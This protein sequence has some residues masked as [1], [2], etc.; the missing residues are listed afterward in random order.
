MRSLSRLTLS[1]TLTWLATVGLAGGCELFRP[2]T[3]EG[4]PPA[5]ELVHED[6]SSPEATLATMVGAVAAKV[7]GVRSWMNSLA[8]PQRDNG[9]AF[10]ALFDET[11]VLAY[12]TG[13]P[14]SWGRTQEETFYGDFL[15]KWRTGRDS[16]AWRPVENLPDPDPDP[17]TPDLRVLIRDYQVWNVT[18]QPD[19]S[20]T[21][22]R[23]AIGRGY[24]T[25]LRSGSA[26]R[27][28]QWDD[29]VDPVITATPP[30][31][32]LQ[33]RSYSWRRLESTGGGS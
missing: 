5:K 7:P 13:A 19:G 4:P 21:Y 3:A 23:I 12:G 16:L 22:Q 15:S 30:A 24:L 2:A 25:F 27:L 20:V 32:Q 31:G 9:A 17:A 26:W 14:S 1:L 18:P 28:L 6:F 8:D 11:V 10:S 33:D 29:R